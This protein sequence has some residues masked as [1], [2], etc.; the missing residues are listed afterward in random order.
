MVIHAKTHVQELI[1][2]CAQNAPMF[3]E[4]VAK[5]PVGACVC[6]HVADAEERVLIPILRFYFEKRNN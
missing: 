2:V 1:K 4:E 6:G 3:V 5:T